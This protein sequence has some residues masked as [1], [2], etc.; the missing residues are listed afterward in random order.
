MALCGTCSEFMKAIVA[1]AAE[2][3]AAVSECGGSSRA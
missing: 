3:L 2:D 1:D